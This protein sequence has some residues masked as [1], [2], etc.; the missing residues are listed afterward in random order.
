MHSSC[1]DRRGALRAASRRQLGLP[2]A[3]FPPALPPLVE[4]RSTLVDPNGLVWVARSF[5]ATDPSR[6]YDVFDNRGVLVSRVTVPR[7]GRV[8]GF[9]KQTVYVVMPDDDDLE[10]I[11]RYAMR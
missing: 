5:K 9:G 10:W 7:R 6:T 11:E 3:A 4:E 1:G 8:V 2:D